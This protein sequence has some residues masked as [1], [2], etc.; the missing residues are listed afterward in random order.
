MCDQSIKGDI[1]R[2]KYIVK[3]II[4]VLLLCSRQNIAIREEGRAYRRQK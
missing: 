4:D 3:E 1:T 2:N